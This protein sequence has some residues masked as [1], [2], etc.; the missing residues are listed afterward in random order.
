MVRNHLR[1]RPEVEQRCRYFPACEIH[2]GAP[3]SSQ[4]QLSPG[5][6]STIR[7]LHF[8]EEWTADDIARHLNIGYSTIFAHLRNGV[9]HHFEADPADRDQGIVADEDGAPAR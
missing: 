8:R 7:A 1:D 9:D 3:S 4:S 5:E 2:V 6:V